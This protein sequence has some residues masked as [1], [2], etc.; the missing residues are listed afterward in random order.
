MATSA[1][2][3]GGVVVGCGGSTTKTNIKT[4]MGS[5]DMAKV[6]TGD[7]STTLLSCS[8]YIDCYSNCATSSADQP[9]YDACTKKCDSEAKPTVLGTSSKPGLYDQALGCAQTYCITGTATFTSGDGAT[10]YKCDVS[11]DGTMFTEIGGAPVTN[12]GVCI[13]CVVAAEAALQGGA[14]ADPTS[15]DCSSNMSSNVVT[16][17]GAYINACL[18]D[19]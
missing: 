8:A 3:L 11:A 15:V 17:C 7:L 5:G 16:A 9:T 2:L 12:K 14:C 1:L 19:K 13:T 6:A 4:D 10:R 18:K